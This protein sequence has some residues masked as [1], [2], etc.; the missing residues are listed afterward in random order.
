IKVSVIYLNYDRDFNTFVQNINKYTNNFYTGIHL[1]PQYEY[2]LNQNNKISNEVKI[3]RVENFGQNLDRIC[4]RF[5]IPLLTEE[6]KKNKINCSNYENN[7]HYRDYYDKKSI[8]IVQN[9]YKLDF[10]KLSYSINL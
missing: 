4:R 9:F 7:K 5:N 1:R 3:Y 2:L 10:F 6:E 8:E